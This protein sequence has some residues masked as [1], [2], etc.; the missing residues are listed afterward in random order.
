MKAV[1]YAWQSELSNRANRSFIED[2]LERALKEI[3]RRRPPE[4]QLF[5][6]QGT[7]DVSGMPDISRVIFDKIDTCAVFVP[8]L[9]LTAVGQGGRKSPN[10]NVLIELGYALRGIG[11]RRV[12]GVF[13]EASGSAEELP[14]DLRRHRWPAV[15]SLS[16]DAKAE[17]RQVVRDELVKD[18]VVRIAAAARRADEDEAGT[19][20]TPTLNVYEGLGPF[21]QGELIANV[22]AATPGADGQGSLFWR[23]APQATIQVRPKAE[24]STEGYVELR[25]RAVKSSFA[26]RAF[27]PR[28]TQWCSQNSRGFI[29]GDVVATPIQP[30]ALCVTQLHKHS[31]MLYGINQALMGEEIGK[32]FVFGARVRPEF[33]ETLRNYLE[34]YRLNSDFGTTFSL[35][36]TVQY[37]AGL[38]LRLGSPKDAYTGPIVESQIYYAVDTFSVDADVADLLKPLF[39]K[40]WDAAGQIYQDAT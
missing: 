18:L 38:Y 36:V 22:D 26:L 35:Y 2:C 33:E 34:F 14:F 9:S 12:V 37:M 25:N 4:A 13:N 23:D 11:E 3:N 27:G 31:G 20:A 1:F 39:V 17:G 24:K 28:G 6:D 40:V 29:A 16:E 30:R 32:R 5:L 21:R 15:Y 8:D 7:Q 19:S 10:A